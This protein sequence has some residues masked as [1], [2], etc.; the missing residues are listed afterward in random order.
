MVLSVQRP[1]SASV[2]PPIHERDIYIRLALE[3]HV[4]VKEILEGGKGEREREIQTLRIQHVVDCA[5]D[6]GCFA[7]DDE[8]MAVGGDECHV[9]R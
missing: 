6:A 7:G 9:G 3:A 8:F 2:N 4:T 1:W 5:C